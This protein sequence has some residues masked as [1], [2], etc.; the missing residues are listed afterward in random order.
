MID[1]YDAFATTN[2]A[3]TVPDFLPPH[4]NRRTPGHYDHK[5][6]IADYDYD[7]V[8]AGV[9]YHG[10]QNLEPVPF[11]PS[12]SGDADHRGE[13]VAVGQEIYNRWLADFVSQA[14]HRHVGLAHLPM[15][16]IEAATAELV[17][18]H[19]S[20]LR[21]VNFPT[22]REGILEYTD[23]DWDP[24][25]SA[26]EE[27]GIPLVTHVPIGAG[28][29]AKVRRPGWY[30]SMVHSMET[31]GWMSRRAIWW[32][33]F[34]G[35]FERHPGL[36]LVI[37]ESPGNWWPWLVAELDGIYEMTMGAARK[38][39]PELVESLPLRPS[40]YMDRNVFFGATFTSPVE[41]K[42]AVDGGFSTQLMWGT[43]YPHMEGTFVYPDGTD[44]P[45]VTKLSLRNGFSGIPEESTRRM[46]GENAIELYNLD[47]AALQAVAREINA[48]TAAELARQVDAVP[49]GAASFAFRTGSSWA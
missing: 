14:P 34:G 15:W 1:D 12:N 38:M 31:G 40:E 45:S 18:A 41:A 9:L 39:M 24:F 29:T 37:T 10:S 27:R 3:H 7:G 4:P 48:P 32:M 16:D 20:G 5:A 47:R 35:V 8:A 21:G 19:D 2:G 36:K 22:L 44:M 46:V 49:E 23:S 11:T 33:I 28:S 26:C 43:D 13:L 30:L 42:A 25:W 6:R 17:R